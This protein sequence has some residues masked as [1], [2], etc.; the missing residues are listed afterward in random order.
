MKAQ[1]QFFP[2]K[3]KKTMEKRSVKSIL[4]SLYF[5][6]LAFFIVCVFAEEWK[7]V[8]KRAK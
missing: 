8:S 7:S 6:Q 4:A 1:T 2:V 3:V 5:I